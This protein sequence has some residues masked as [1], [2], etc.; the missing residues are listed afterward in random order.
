MGDGLLEEMLALEHRVWAALVAGDVAA[1]AALLDDGFLG[2]YPDGFEGKAAHVGQ[3]SAGAT[4]SAYAIAEARVLPLGADH[5][6]LV[7]R[8]DYSRA[9]TGARAVM[10]V[11]SIW[12]RSDAGWRNVFSQDTPRGPAGSVC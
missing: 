9:D 7:Y 12:R 10:Y 5:A 6:V 11:S 1:D 8:A 4:V 3:L 2:V